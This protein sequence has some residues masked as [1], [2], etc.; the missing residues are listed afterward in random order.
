MLASVIALAAL[1][2]F[3]PSRDESGYRFIAVGFLAG[4]VAAKAGNSRIRIFN[5]AILD[6]R[7]LLRFP[8]LLFFLLAPA[9]RFFKSC[10]LLRHHAG[11][12]CP[13]H[14]VAGV[15]ALRIALPDFFILKKAVGRLSALNHLR[16]LIAHV[17]CR[18]GFDAA[19]CVAAVI[20]LHFVAVPLKM[21]VGK[22]RPIFSPLGELLLVVQAPVFL[23]R[24]TLRP[25]LLS[26]RA[27]TVGL[28][29][30]LLLD[31]IDERLSLSKFE[32]LEVWA[33]LENMAA[34]RWQR[35]KRRVA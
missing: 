5:P 16:H 1:P 22:V 11:A 10:V 25:N 3:T 28:E 23:L 27:Y 15:A 31:I 2:H 17:L 8:L 24:E 26:V 19:G 13:F 4:F 6:R 18:L 20:D 14:A 34:R 21:A 30:A 29:M 32:K 7:G 35:A 12:V 9:L 33:M